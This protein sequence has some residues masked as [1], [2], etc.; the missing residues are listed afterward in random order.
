MTVVG[1]EIDEV[2]R[3]IRAIHDP[4]TP[5]ALENL[6]DG[7]PVQSIP[8]AFALIGNVERL[9]SHVG[10]NII[11][12][13]IRYKW[14][15]LEGET[16]L[17]I[18][19][20]VLDYIS[21]GSFSI[22]VADA[23]IRTAISRAVVG[24]MEHEWP[25][26]WPEL[27]PQF[28]A[29]SV[30]AKYGVQCQMVFLVLKRLI[31]NVFTLVSVEDNV[32]RKKLQS[33]IT[34]HTTEIIQMIVMRI[35]L[36]VS[37]GNDEQSVLLS[38]AAIELLA[39]IFEWAS[40]SVLA[41]SIDEIVEVLCLYLQTETCGIYE[42]TARCL[43]KL[44]SRKRVK[45][46]EL[47][48]VISIFRDQ[49]MQS[50]LAACNLAASSSNTSLEH[51]QFLKALCDL[52]CSLGV[53]L[54]EVWLHI[55]NPPANFSLYLSV[56]AEFFHHPSLYIRLETS[57]VLVAFSSNPSICRSP[58]LLEKMPAILTSLPKSI[59]KVG[60]LN[61]TN[62]PTY[63][64][65]RMDY[66]SEADFLQD[67]TRLRERCNR[68]I[69]ENMSQHFTVLSSIVTTW[70]NDRCVQNAEN[71]PPTEWDSMKRY[72]TSYLQA[73]QE[74]DMLN[75]DV[76]QWLLILMDSVFNRL[77]TLNNP[78]V[79]NEMLSILSSFSPLLEFA[80]E[81]ITPI[82]E[83]LKR[84]LSL[85]E[86]QG[87]KNENFG[88]ESGDIV[89]L[90]RHCINLLLKLVKT[91]PEVA[92]VRDRCLHY[93]N[94]LQ[95]YVDNILDVVVT[96][97]PLVTAMQKASLVQVLAA[98]SNVTDSWEHQQIFL[99]SALRDVIVVFES[100]E[101]KSCLTP[102]GFLSYIG[103]L[104]VA[105]TTNK[106]AFTSPFYENRL[107]LKSHLSIVE[108]AIAQVNAP[109]NRPNPLFELCLPA[110]RH[111]FHLV[112]CINALHSDSVSAL[113]HMSYGTK[114]I[115]MSR[116]QQQDIIYSSSSGLDTDE[117]TPTQFVEH[118]G[119]AHMRRFITDINDI[120]QNIIGQVGQRLGAEFYKLED[121]SSLV[122]AAFLNA[123]YL[124]DFRLRFW[125]K[126]AWSRLIT[127]C[128]AERVE[129][130]APITALLSQHMYTVLTNRWTAIENIDMDSTEVGDNELFAQQIVYILSR[131]YADWL[132]TLVL[133]SGVFARDD[134]KKPP[135]EVMT[136]LAQQLLKDRSVLQ[137][138]VASICT[139]INCPD[140]RVVTKLLPVA[141]QV[142]SAYHETF[143]EQMATNVFIHC[144][145]S[146][147]I[148]GSD[149][150]CVGPLLGLAFSVY[151]LIR[152]RFP[153]IVT[154][155]QQVPDATVEKMSDFDSR[156]LQYV[157]NTE[158]M[159][160]KNKRD[161]MRKILRP[162][163]ARKESERFK[164]PAP[165]YPIHKLSTRMVQ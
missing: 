18:R 16:K 58:A 157:Q 64:Y 87:G 41:Q 9:I 104:S 103:A 40:G 105:S 134:N 161:L 149:D 96:V 151:S 115:S 84:L 72:I 35:R 133:G 54:A 138:I 165:M 117:L 110:L 48:M 128:P 81:R 55:T 143:D 44:A 152:P 106:E 148:N 8:T 79:T 23:P 61:D 123:E 94:N 53:H 130:I 69:R 116:S 113:I 22:S 4:E 3:A 140:T 34:T 163:I 27:L 86:A 74:L 43:Y 52:L 38:K 131:D 120:V 112:T 162:M 25:E 108:G 12:H 125:L 51:Y 99:Q 1:N 85:S 95:Q 89:V 102:Q 19:N 135:N 75:K 88:N 91:L 156:V 14:H 100:D 160:E 80:T 146:L 76:K 147:Q 26:N 71:I 45:T 39:E 114:I 154:V 15:E 109:A 164:R 155:L 56:L 6:K 70:I 142:F 118:D 150:A 5:N 57:H 2:V 20:G 11:E 122:E 33:A 59:E 139:L 121:A 7:S 159:I 73:A 107:K 46:D 28:S 153:N 42:V 49:P 24:I 68:L 144:V 129:V 158:S 50:I 126:R 77:C 111:V 98:L 65:S 66:D 145:R 37:I 47:P 124:P 30:D 31:E 101:F 83:L 137:P 132:S 32:R 136:P 93:T 97:A 119:I 62:S 36:S 29:I 17:K 10:W 90:K 13:I 78:R 127:G 21:S 82:L 92:K 141:R 63:E 67:Y 60:Q